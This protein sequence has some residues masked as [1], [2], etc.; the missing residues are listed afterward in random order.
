MF[1]LLKYQKLLTFLVKNPKKNCHVFLR[2]FIWNHPYT[3]IH[4]C[5]P[6]LANQTTPLSPLAAQ[7][8]MLC[9]IATPPIKDVILP[10]Q[11]DIK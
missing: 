3:T 2:A 5:L 7:W 8:A 4:Q 6:Y 9:Q 11:C 10:A 1:L